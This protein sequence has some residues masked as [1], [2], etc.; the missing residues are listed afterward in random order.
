MNKEIK[1]ALDV[2]NRK[3][4]ILYPT[5]TVWGLGCDACDSSA[6]RRLYSIKGKRAGTA[7]IVLVANLDM[8]Y[9][10]VRKVP[11]IAL[12]LIEVADGP[13]TLVLPGACGVAPEIV[14][15][16]GSIG[17]RLVRHDYCAALIRALRR[18]LVSTSANLAG[19]PTPKGFGNIAPEILSAVDYA[20]DVQ[21]AG[22]MTGKPSPVISTGLS[23]EVRI[24]RN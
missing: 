16:D 2:L 1:E 23:G 17:I 9:D 12:D 15:E 11:D 14:A 24:I 22:R 18:P 13:L 5:D 3:G 6:V 10:C 8:L 7:A 21:H 20:V 4:T 19:Q